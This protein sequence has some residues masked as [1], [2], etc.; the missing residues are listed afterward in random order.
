[1]SLVEDN[2]LL[3]DFLLKKS[4]IKSYS[5]DDDFVKKVNIHICSNELTFV[6]LGKSK[7]KEFS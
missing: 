7:L 4:K 5:D 6:F 3:K 1:M 2:I